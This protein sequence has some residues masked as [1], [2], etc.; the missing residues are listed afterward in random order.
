[1]APRRLRVGAGIAGLAVAQRAA[2]RGLRPLVL[3]RD[4]PGGGATHV[5]AGMLAPVSEAAFGG[6]ALLDLNLAAAARYPDWIAELREATGRDAGYRRCGTLLVARD[7]DQAEA[8]ERE[9]AFRREAGLGVERLRPSQARRLEPA[10]APQVRLAL[11]ASDDHAV[12][13]RALAEVLVAALGDGG[14]GGGG[15]GRRGGKGGGR[16]GAGGGG[17]PTPRRSW[18]RG[19]WPACTGRPATTATACCSRRSR[20]TSWWPGSS[21]R[22][23]TG[24]R[25]SRR[26]SPP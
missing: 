1:M 3:D 13:P 10:L 7:R 18:G 8:L 23:P 4:A 19:R 26:R 24:S 6:R 22:P 20:P 15:R 9:L 25:R 21:T 17:P 16:G 5:A 12:D 2:T 14:R 11:E